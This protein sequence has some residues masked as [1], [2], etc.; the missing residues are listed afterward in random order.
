MGL[1]Q[2]VQ[3]VVN[4][5]SQLLLDGHTRWKDALTKINANPPTYTADNF[6]EDVTQMALKTLFLG[7]KLWRPLGDPMLPTVSISALANK[8]GGATGDASLVDVIAPGV[9]L[10]VT[11]LVFIGAPDSVP[12][13]PDPVNVPPLLPAAAPNPQFMDPLRQQIRVT[14]AAPGAAP[15]T[16]I[17]Q[18]YVLNAQ[19]PVAV[20]VARIL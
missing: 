20:V 3:D 4:G 1:F 13:N 11:N 6:T 5:T 2:R 8:V 19:N 17:Y 10:T 14:L 9:N 15:Q 12:P 18:G 7:M 16:G